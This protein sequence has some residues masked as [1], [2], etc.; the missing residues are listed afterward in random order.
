M[1]NCTENPCQTDDIWSGRSQ[2][3]SRKPGATR[4]PGELLPLPSQRC[5]HG[6]GGSWDLVT[7][8]SH[9]TEQSGAIG[10]HLC[11]LTIDF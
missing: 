1:L 10:G 2:A 3:G 4:I 6:Q 11:D 9:M 7:S 5:C 8:V